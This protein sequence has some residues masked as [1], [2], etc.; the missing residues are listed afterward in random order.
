MNYSIL[1][2]SKFERL[3]KS[4]FS[5]LFFVVFSSLHA[6]PLYKEYI[7]REYPEDVYHTQISKSTL[8]NVEIKIIEIF[9]KKYFENKK[10][11]CRAWIIILKHD[12]VISK[13]Y[14]DNMAADGGCS[15]LYWPKSQ[16]AN[17]FIVSKFGDYD[18]RTLL[19]DT[20]AVIHNIPGG[21]FFISRDSRF[22]FS[23]YDSDRNGFA[24]FDMRLCKTAYLNDSL[25]TPVAQW[26]FQGGKYFSIDEEAD[27]EADDE[28][29]SFNPNGLMQFTIQT[30]DFAKRSL[31]QEKLPFENLK[32]ESKIKLFPEIKNITDCQCK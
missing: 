4:V 7:E 16:P 1:E 3:L 5:V 8:K 31:K 27:D 30:F 22:V 17:Y 10:L 21:R 2:Q 13:M 18:G 19:I 25:A 20:N 28:S 9:N 24:V 32:E 26:Y 6:Q 23:V 14:F 15:G 11:Y 12:S 29:E